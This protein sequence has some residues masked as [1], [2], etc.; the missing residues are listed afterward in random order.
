MVYSLLSISCDQFFF[1]CGWVSVRTWMGV[2]KKK[3]QTSFL[4]FYNFH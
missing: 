4:L 3:I 2:R 1:T